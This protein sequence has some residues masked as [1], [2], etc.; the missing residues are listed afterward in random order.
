MTQRLPDEMLSM[1]FILGLPDC[2]DD[3]TPINLTTMPL[4]LTCVCRRWRQVAFSTPA[5]WSHLF[6]PQ[7][8]QNA[9]LLDSF[10]ATVESWF[11]LTRSPSLHIRLDLSG[12][13]RSDVASRYMHLLSTFSS[14]WKII[15]IDC[16]TFAHEADYPTLNHGSVSQLA[17][18]QFMTNSYDN[19]HQGCHWNIANLNDVLS[20]APNLDSLILTHPN[21]DQLSVRWSNMVYLSLEIPHDSAT[22]FDLLRF[23][24]AIGCCVNL[25]TLELEFVGDFSNI[26]I[27]TTGWGPRILGELTHFT[28]V[29]TCPYILMFL[30][31]LKAP[32]LTSFNLDTIWGTFRAGVSFLDTLCLAL[33]CFL[34]Y[35]KNTL[36]I[37]ALRSINFLVDEGQLMQ[38]LQICDDL[39]SLTIVDSRNVVGPTTLQSLTYRFVN[40]D[41][42]DATSTFRLEHGCSHPFLED[43]GLYHDDL[44]RDASRGEAYTDDMYSGLANMVESRWW[45]PEGAMTS[46]DVENG[47][48]P[49]PV[50]K[51][52]VLR[53]HQ[54]DE[55]WMMDRR[56]D[57]WTRILRCCDEGLKL[58]IEDA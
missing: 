6:L 2:D 17:A 18:F 28:L 57:D 52:K 11:S 38:N 19:G 50:A 9:Q 41:P 31:V 1:V 55:D 29:G 15:N 58:E 53:L 21:I 42:N 30:P 20:S 46:C 24:N 48:M 43:I 26:S 54:D 16:R 45:C 14:R 25:S 40:P 51:L 33:S 44:A 8:P 56:P 3:L 13:K 47:L 37:L 27:A 32:S 34:R 5:L 36:W 23:V 35:H 4:I 22:P 49:R 39:R 7:P 10:F 12:E